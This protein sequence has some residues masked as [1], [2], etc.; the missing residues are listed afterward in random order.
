MVSTGIG[1]F[2]QNKLK[3]VAALCV[4]SAD[5]SE[6]VGYGDGHVD[7]YIHNVLAHT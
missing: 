7:F 5:G 1:I 3:Y 6:Y 4:Y 2:C